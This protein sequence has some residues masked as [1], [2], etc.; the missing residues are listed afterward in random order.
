MIPFDEEAF[1]WVMVNCGE[2]GGVGGLLQAVR[3]ET[4]RSAIGDWFRE[5]PQAPVTGN[6]DVQTQ[7]QQRT[8]DKEVEPQSKRRELERER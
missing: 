7:P 2:L 1:E 6:R 5:E 4:P 8:G 3:R